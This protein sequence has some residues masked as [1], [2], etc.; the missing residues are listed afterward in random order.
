MTVHDLRQSAYN[1]TLMLLSLS[2]ITLLN[3]G[4]V[5]EEAPKISLAG[6]NDVVEDPPPAVLWGCVN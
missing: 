1:A 5:D 6:Q 2:I 3:L 4:G